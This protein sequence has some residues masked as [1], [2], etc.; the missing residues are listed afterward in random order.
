MSNHI[1]R[2]GYGK[3]PYLLR[4]RK[5]RYVNEIWAAD[6]TYIKLGARWS[7]IQLS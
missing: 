7:I 4:N 3:H 1:L 2:K 5:I 6:I